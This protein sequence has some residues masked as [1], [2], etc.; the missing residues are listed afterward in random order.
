MKITIKNETAAY[1]LKKLSCPHNVPN[2]LLIAEVP[3]LVSLPQ[4][5]KSVSPQITPV[6][7]DFF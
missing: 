6:V 2:F 7:T 3:N 4:E 5:T 1:Y